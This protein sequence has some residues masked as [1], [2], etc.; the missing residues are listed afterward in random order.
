MRCDIVIFFYSTL[1][2]NKRSRTC[3]QGIDDDIRAGV[4]EMWDQTPHSPALDLS[5]ND[6]AL[7]YRLHFQSSVVVI[8]GSFA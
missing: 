6:P 7:K 2:S 5:F 3:T 1:A 4:G 8:I